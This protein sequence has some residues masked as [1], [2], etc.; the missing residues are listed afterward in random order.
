MA[1]SKPD[2]GI[3]VIVYLSWPVECN[4]NSCV[5]LNNFDGIKIQ[6]K[7]PTIDNLGENIRAYAAD[8]MLFKVDL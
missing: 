5:I 7:C 1:R 3:R 2:G 4:V 6:L 8:T